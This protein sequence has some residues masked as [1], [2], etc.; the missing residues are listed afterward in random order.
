M[1]NEAALGM[2][3]DIA[4]RLA[5][6]QPRK[7]PWRRQCRRAAVSIILDACGDGA[8]PAALMISR[9][10]RHGDPWSGH[11]AFPGG[12]VDR[13]DRH[14][15]AT[16]L[17]ELHEE[18]GIE[19][20]VLRYLGRLSDVIT[21]PHRGWGMLAVTPFVFALEREVPLLPNHEVGQ[22]LW[23]PLRWLADEEQRSILRWKLKGRD[24]QLP[25]YHYQDKC[26]W[27][28]SLAMLDE[29]LEVLW[30]CRFANR[31]SR[32]QL[33]SAFLWWLRQ[34]WPR[35]AANRAPLRDHSVHRDIPRS[36]SDSR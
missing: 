1:S 32:W 13:S 25:C 28:L 24:L 18:V 35:P 14:V 30:Q 8:S 21:R 33:R 19:A 34:L 4:T 3:N 22:T 9:A 6:H 2:T 16:A 11:M 5:R 29:L 20:G 36:G 31:S 15:Y 17:R 10:E 7:L 26:I 23:I 27:G 12:T